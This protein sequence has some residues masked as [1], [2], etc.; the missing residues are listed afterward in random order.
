MV[1]LLGVILGRLA[2]CVSTTY[3]VA[4]STRRWLALSCMALLRRPIETKTTLVIMLL[5]LINAVIW[6]TGSTRLWPL[7]AI[8]LAMTLL[9]ILA[10]LDWRYYLL[11]DPLVYA[12][13]WSGLFWSPWL[14]LDLGS[15]V[16]GILVGFITT[17]LLDFAYFS[18]TGQRGIGQGDIKLC[19]ALGA[20][21]GWQALPSLFLLASL[22]ALS[23]WL[24]NAVTGRANKRWI[25]FGSHLCLAGGAMIVFL[26]TD[27]V[28]RLVTTF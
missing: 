28:S 13:L 12:L 24:F 22:A 8:L 11:P 20:W 14:S 3:N 1:W 10:S 7:I 26:H 23:V 27:F 9:V 21:V 4:I 16:C 17:F 25:P 19:A 2:L 18:C 5:S 15:A 6:R